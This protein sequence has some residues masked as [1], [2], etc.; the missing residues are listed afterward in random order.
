MIAAYKA[1]YGSY[2]TTSARCLTIDNAC[3]NYNGTALTSD[4]AA[5]IAELQK[6]GSVVSSVPKAGTF[7]GVYYDYYSPRTYN[8]DKIPTLVMYWLEGDNQQCQLSNTVVGLPATPEEPNKFGSSTT[9]YPST[10]WRNTLR[11]LLHTL[12]ISR[13][14]Q[15][16][17]AILLALGER[18]IVTARQMPPR[19]RY[20]PLNYLIT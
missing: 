15:L 18:T 11:H 3:T 20:L 9:G 13:R 8:G 6:V 4:N 5:A 12:P 1:T 16:Q 10:A 7:Y 17:V 2:P 19:R 14:I